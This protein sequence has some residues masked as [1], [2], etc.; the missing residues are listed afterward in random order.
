M[1]NATM[2][3]GSR[4]SFGASFDDIPVPIYAREKILMRSR[5]PSKCNDL[6][7]VQYLLKRIY[8]QRQNANPPLNQAIGTANL[9]IDG[10]Y[11]PKTQKAIE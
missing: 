4:K 10:L 11:E 6:M 5:E 1:Y 3:V 7:L 9:K 8:Q 2:T